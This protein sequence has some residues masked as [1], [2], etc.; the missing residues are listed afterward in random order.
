MSFTFA[1]AGKGGTG[2]TT[3]AAL[4]IKY[5]IE[6]RR[7]IVLAVDAD[8]NA[9]L[10]EKLGVI[11]EKTI[12][13]LRENLLKESDNIPS[14]MTKTEY[15]EYQIRTALTEGNGFDLLVM[16]R[17]EGPGCYC[18]INNL[19]RTFIDNLAQKYDFVV[20]DNEAGME[21]L[22]RRTTRDVDVLT[23]IADPTRQGIFTADRINKLT[24]EMELH[25]KKTV[26]VLNKVTDNINI[27]K[28]VS[29]SEFNSFETIPYDS[30]LE[31]FG[32]EGTNLLILPRDAVSYLA[33]S[34]IIGGV[35]KN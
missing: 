18:Y 6:H 20:L 15:L 12:G 5:L 4:V 3:I 13:S 23:I 9:N 28:L 14:G 1:V 8:P 16:G 25:I 34:K 7:K 19:L 22:S 11:V 17:Q 33:I 2:K 27:K 26:L 35:L 29:E 24:Q 31:K 30:I 32:T 21:H 10:N